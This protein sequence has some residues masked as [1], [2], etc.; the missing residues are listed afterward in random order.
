M[1]ER[2]EQRQHAYRANCW[3]IELTGARGR[4]TSLDYAR[5][6]LFDPGIRELTP[7][8]DALRG[9]GKP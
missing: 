7:R 9:N 2:L 3:K 5:D 1:I 4:F 6:Y 8:R